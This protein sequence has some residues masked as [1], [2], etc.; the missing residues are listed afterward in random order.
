MVFAATANSATSTEENPLTNV[1]NGGLPI[2]S[3]EGNVELSGANASGEE[4]TVTIIVV[5][6]SGDLAKKKIFPS[7]FALFCE[8]CLP[9]VSTVMQILTICSH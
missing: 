2:I 4:S 8:E 9:K 7:L 3:S 6:A 1:G 5:G